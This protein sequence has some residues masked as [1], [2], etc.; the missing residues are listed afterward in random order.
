MVSE[1]IKREMF[2]CLLP[3]WREQWNHNKNL[4]ENN[5]FAYG[6]FIG[7]RYRRY[8]PWI[9]WVMGGDEAPDTP[10]KLNVHR[11]LARGVAWGINGKEEYANILM[12][13][14]THG[15]TT[16][17][18]FIPENELFMDFNTIQSGHNINNLEGMIERSWQAQK[19]PV[20]DFEPYYTKDGK[21]TNE[22]RTAIYWGIFSG[23][24]GT[25]YG[26]WNIWHCGAR[27]DLAE[28]SIPDAFF[29]G[30]GTQIRHLGR[31]LTEYPMLLREPDQ[32]FLVNNQTKGADR[33]L[34][35]TA[36]DKSYALV[37]TP[38]GAPFMADLTMVNGKRIYWYWFNPRNG[39]TPEKGSL[40]KTNTPQVF[41]PP[42]NGQRF[43]G[44]D[45]V[46]IINNGG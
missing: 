14:H 39:E 4:H 8:N 16:T 5:A 20:M 23:G 46:L 26:S 9:I 45:W 10:L 13:Y 41:I 27:N 40:R 36:S 42:T 37:Y 21:S 3:T 7:Q 31:L 30:F 32:E 15:P 17:T 38:H 25:S 29:E 11:E 34:A 19:K 44:N 24:F 35:C 2:I 22:A 12:T 6:K 28:F 33:I 43:S 1:C 18:D